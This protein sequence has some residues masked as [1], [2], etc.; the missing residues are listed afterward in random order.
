MHVFSFPKKDQ[1]RFDY[2][3]YPQKTPVMHILM[4]ITILELEI[5]N[6]IDALF[7]NEEKGRHCILSNNFW[8]EWDLNPGPNDSNASSL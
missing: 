2:N 7:L 5:I 4:G 1:S 3:D 8:V 6:E